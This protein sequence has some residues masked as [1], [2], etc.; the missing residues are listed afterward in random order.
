MNTA[1]LYFI[2]IVDNIHDFLSWGTVGITLCIISYI[3]IM[4]SVS[5]HSHDVDLPFNTVWTDPNK[6]FYNAIRFTNKVLV[7][8]FI[9]Q[10]VGM[11]IPKQKNM[12]MLIAGTELYPLVTSDRAKQLGEKAATLIEKKLDQ[13]LNKGDDHAN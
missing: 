3:V 2:S 9:M 13:E 4:I 5:S 6:P 8:C 11:M 1:A 10:A 12:I 7:V